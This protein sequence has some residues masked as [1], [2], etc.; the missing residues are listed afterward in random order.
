MVPGEDHK[1]RRRKCRARHVQ[2]MPGRLWRARKHWSA[3][4]GAPFMAHRPCAGDATRRGISPK[5]PV[6]AIDGKVLLHQCGMGTYLWIEGRWLYRLLGRRLQRRGYTPRRSIRLRQRRVESQL[7]RQGRRYR[8][9]L[10]RQRRWP[11]HFAGRPAHLSQCGF[12]SDLRVRA[13][14][15]SSCWGEFG[16]VVLPR[17]LR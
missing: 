5:Q 6:H 14:G 15:Y 4:V 13:D 16:S 3:A 8:C 11:G 7:R 1:R 12:I 10:G 17:W 2:A 9:L